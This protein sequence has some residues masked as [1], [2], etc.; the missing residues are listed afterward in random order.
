MVHFQDTETSIRFKNLDKNEQL[1]IIDIG[2]YIYFNGLKLYSDTSIEKEIYANELR[3]QDVKTQSENQLQNHTKAVQ[4]Q[5]EYIIQSKDDVID[6][7]NNENIELKQRIK[8]LEEQTCQAFALSRKLDSLMGKGNTVDNAMKGDFGESIVANQIQYWYQASEIEDKSAETARGDL[9]WKLNDCDFAALVEVKN[10]QMVR[11]SEVQKFERDLLV[12][13]NDK[14]CTCGIFI[15][16]KTETIPNK[17]KFKLEFINNVP[18][19]YVSNI[20][21]DLNTL[22]FAL[23][24]LVC[25]HSKYKLLYNSSQS[26]TNTLFQES[27][28]EF[29][30]KLFNKLSCM[31]SNLLQ[32]KNSVDT[33]ISCIAHEEN[34]IKELTT[35][36]NVLRTEYDELK[37]IEIEYKANNRSELKEQILKDM[38]LFREEKG[39]IPQMSEM[40]T[41]YKQSVFRDELAYKKLKIEI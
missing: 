29:I 35:N 11:P 14:S 40:L 3:L 22:R 9:L 1:K 17:G 23:D 41:K 6:N 13:T 4:N 25:I 7:K 26:D 20:L 18:V 28:V 15:S 37:N 24:A 12:N 38:R 19:I 8:D 5:Y 16:L 10:V 33:L 21:N 34:S 2:E 39:R 30:Q 31:S 32:M 27:M 36:I